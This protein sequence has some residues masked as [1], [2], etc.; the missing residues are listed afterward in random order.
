MDKVEIGA[1]VFICPMTVTLVGTTVAGRANFMAV[2]WISR[3]NASPPM[4]AIGINKKHYT[5]EG[6]KENKAFSINFPKT[7]MIEKVDYCGLVS[8][9]NEDKSG[10]FELFY[11]RLGS[12]PMIK[13]CPLCIECRLHDTVE[14]PTND[15]FIGGIA[16]A[17]TDER[18]LTDGKLDP[19]K[20]DPLMLTMPDNSYWTLGEKVGN[21][22]SDGR[23]L[24]SKA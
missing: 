5:A 12:A 6:I 19:R 9:R 4:L 16:G 24:I 3:V 1:N 7:E 13:D 17:Y 21:A 10:T 20:I 2:G 11:G 14:L 18:Y 23:R 15:L 8:G 22:W